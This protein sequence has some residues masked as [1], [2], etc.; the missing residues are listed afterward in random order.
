MIS[1]PQKLLSNAG[2][3]DLTLRKRS[4]GPFLVKSGRS[5]AETLTG[6]LL[7][8]AETW[9]HRVQVSALEQKNQVPQYL[10]FL[11]YSAGDGT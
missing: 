8:K 5:Y 1:H 6:A 11:F 10:I 4:G 2:D 3:G 9:T 7:C